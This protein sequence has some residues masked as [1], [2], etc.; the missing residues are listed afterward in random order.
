MIVERIVPAYYDSNI[1]VINKK[2]LIDAGMSTDYILSHL[3]NVT[4]VS[5]IELIILT[6][7]HYDHF[8]A[9]PA[10]I[11]KSGAKLAIYET[12][13]SAL[14]DEDLSSALMFGH[15]CPNLTPD[16]LCHDGDKIPI[17]KGE[18]GEEEFL[19]VIHTPGHTSGCMCLYEKSSKSLFSG[20]TLFSEGGIGR[21]DF[22]NS[23][24]EKMTKSI[25]KLTALDIQN[26]YPGHG[27]PTLKNANR[28]VE[29]SLKFS[30]RM[31]P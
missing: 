29:L 23:A 13:A 17:G 7:A 12:E 24:A 3:E 11:K 2:I 10:I 15:T 4:P 22:G 25:Q 6:H 1:Y 8:G 16:I 20:D 5:D 31:N 9:A 28:S 19:E 27:T 26:L 30:E 14:Q 18:N 21:A